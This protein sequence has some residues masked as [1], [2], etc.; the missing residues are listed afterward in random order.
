[1]LNLNKKIKVVLIIICFSALILLPQVNQHALILGGDSSFHWNRIYDAMMQIKNGNFQYFVSMYGF[2][3]SGRIVN[4]LY[5]PYIAYFNGLIML[6]AGSWFKYQILSDWVLNMIASFSMYYLLRSNK[7]RPN[8]SVWLSLL[9]VTSYS[10][11]TWTLNQQFLA[12][13]TAI[14]PLG[15]A[16]ATRMV[17]NHA[18]QVNIFELT[19][20]VTLLIQT[21]VL[22]AIFLIIILVVFF[23]LGMIISNNRKLMIR[24]ILV[25]VVLTMLLTSNIWGALLEVYNSNNLLPPFTNLDPL[26]NGVVK[27]LLDNSQLSIGFA[28]LISVQFVVITSYYHKITRLNRMVTTIGIILLIMSTQLLPWNT[29]FTIFPIMSVIQ[30]PYRLLAPATIL[31]ILGMGLSATELSDET[32]QKSDNKLIILGSLIVLCTLISLGII[33]NK[34]SIW[35]TNEVLASRYNVTQIFGG[36]RLRREFGSQNMGDALK[37]VWKPAP[38]YLP[39]NDLGNTVSPYTQYQKQIGTNNRFIKKVKNGKLIIFWISKNTNPTTVSA[40]KY[41]HTKLTLNRNVLNKNDYTLSQIGAIR[42][43][44][45]IGQNILTLEYL[46]SHLFKT[47]I[48]I[49]W[50][51]WIG[52]ILWLGTT[53]VLKQRRLIN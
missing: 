32:I 9:F 27:F 47:L 49:N 16:A 52:L 17:R 51:S 5:G 15:I 35:Q 6:I 45:K 22:S 33:Q 26:N 48:I 25:S 44:P 29:I 37:Y 42:L 30:F 46:P 12:W 40:V 39:T 8:Y 50:I 13:G 38:D 4:A 43:T 41:K 20:G 2:S 7:V 53:F 31:L 10:I 19:L 21:H 28:L 23:I 24:N 36:E 1:M 14:M 34:A 3:Q 11:S 18:R